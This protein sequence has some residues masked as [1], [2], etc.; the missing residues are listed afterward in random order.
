MIPTLEEQFILGEETPLP[1]IAIAP[2]VIPE[3]THP[4]GKYWEQPARE[5]ILIDDKN[6]LMNQADFDLLADYSCSQPS[7]VYEGKMWKC[8]RPY[9]I[10]KGITPRWFLLWFGFSEKPDCCS[11]YVREIII[12]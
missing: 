12:L 11:T 1:A 10:T 8:R 9:V 3:I 7:G 6:A 2:N 5:N 4:Y